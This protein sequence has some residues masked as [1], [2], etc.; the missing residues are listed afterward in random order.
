MGGAQHRD[1][2]FL[3]VMKVIKELINLEDQNDPE[4]LVKAVQVALREI[5]KNGG[6]EAEPVDKPVRQVSSDVKS[7]AS[8]M[9]DR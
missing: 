2:H 3:R 9:S 8:Q 6:L 7:V 5:D 1:S 4:A